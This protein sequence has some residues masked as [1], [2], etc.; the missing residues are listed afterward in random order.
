M[1]AFFIP[2]VDDDTHLLEHAYAGM[3]RQIQADLERSPLLDRP[4]LRYY[5]IAHLYNAQVPSEE[6]QGYRVGLS[7]LLNSFSWVP[8]ITPPRPIGPAGAIL[9]IDLRDYGWTPETWKSSP[10]SSL[11]KATWIGITGSI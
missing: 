9:R 5:S 7:K 1:T 4:F 3:R 6:L 10:G 11:G 2:G 8:R